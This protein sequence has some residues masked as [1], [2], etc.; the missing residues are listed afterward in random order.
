[1]LDF[2]LFAFSVCLICMLCFVSASLIARTL[3]RAGNAVLSRVL[4][5]LL[6]GLFGA[7]RD[8]RDC[9]R[10]GGPVLRFS[11]GRDNLLIS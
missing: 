6:S 8:Q 2:A 3:G 11:W 7:I 10:P 9:G 5:M 1:M 4:G